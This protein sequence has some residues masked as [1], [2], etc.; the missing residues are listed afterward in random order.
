MTAL[1]ICPACNGV[2]IPWI[3]RGPS[4]LPQ[5]VLRHIHRLERSGNIVVFCPDCYFGS[6]RPLTPLV[7]QYRPRFTERILGERS[8]ASHQRQS[9]SGV[10]EF[11]FPRNRRNKNC[12]ICLQRYRKSN[13]CWKLLCKHYFHKDCIKTWLSENSTCPYCRQL[14]NI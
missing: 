3:E 14:T 2:T 10:V 13:I 8:W 6:S 9:A 7:L 11:S 1:P 4:G 12:G 5:S